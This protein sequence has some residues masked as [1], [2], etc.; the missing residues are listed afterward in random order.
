V[1][2]ASAGAA[3]SAASGHDWPRFGWSVSRSSAPSFATGITAAN[4]KSLVKQQVRLDGTVDSSAIYLHA[5][6]AGGAT[7]DVFFVTTTYGKTEA[8]DA[9]T[10]NVLWRF[11]PPGYSS[12]AGSA[13]ITTATP[14]ADP[15]RQFLYAAA[16]N[17]RIY[18][19][20]VATG[21]AVWSVSITKLPSREK[22]AAS[23][24]YFG[25]RVIATTGGYIGDAP[26]YQGHVA[27]IRA[28]NGRLLHVCNSLCSN[29]A[30]L[31]VPSSCATSDSAIWGRAG[32]VVDPANGELL[33]ATGNAAYNGKTMW[34]DSVLELS[35]D[36]GKLLQAY[37][38]K[39]AAYLEGT[40]LDLGS[41]SPAILAKDLIVQTGKDGKLR[42]LRLDKLNGKTRSPAKIQGGELQILPGPR[43]HPI[44]TA[45]AVW[46]SGGRTWTFVGNYSATAGYLLLPGAKPRLKRVWQVT[47]G[48]SSPVVAGGLLF[49]FD[50]LEGGV[51]VYRPATGTLVTTLP[52]GKGHWNSPIV[53]DGRV[54][55]TAGDSND[56]R[57]TSV[58]DIFRLPG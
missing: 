46:R 22:I 26:P 36:A 12:W 3:S 21:R 34:G 42:L 15:G 18:K 4:A 33:V 55:V 57:G 17:G 32:A 25:G 20:A 48:S 13:Q 45:P 14:V 30:G 1:L 10:G 40:D 35:P 39:N 28:S 9:A 24:N 23:L 27:V 51:H 6:R 38:P 56:H 11:T 43:S 52:T 44:L 7:R 47:K 50:P 54:A 29:R 37:T 2:A 49:C 8:V 16:P 58:L 5:V 53:A 31:L 41:A 19:L